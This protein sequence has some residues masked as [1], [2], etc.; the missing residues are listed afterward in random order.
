MRPRTPLL[1]AVTVAL[2]LLGAVAPAPA[3]PQPVPVC[4][5]CGVSFVE[6]AADHGVAVEVTNSTARVQYHENG[7]ATWTVTNTVNASAADR[8]RDE[9]RLLASIAGEAAR[10]GYGLPSLDD[11][12]VV[13]VQ[14]SAVEGDTVTLRFTHD[15]AADRHLGLLVVDALHTDGVRGGWIVN[16]DTFTVV[17]PPGSA[18]VNDPTS[19]VDAEHAPSV[20]G[21]SVTWTGSV[22]GR[23]DHTFYAD[24]YVVFGEDPV[25][26]QAF[27]AVALASAPLVV[28]NVVGFVLPPTLLFALGAGLYAWSGWRPGFDTQ[29]VAGLFVGA[30]TLALAHPLFGVAL[31]RS[32]ES[33]MLYGFGAGLLATGLAAREETAPLGSPAR[34]ALL[35]PV[36][37]YA[38]TAVL[39]FLPGATEYQTTVE[40]ATYALRESAL[41]L[42]FVALYWVGVSTAGVGRR[43]RLRRA[44]PLVTLYAL[45]LASRLRLTDSIFGLA[46]F[47]YVLLTVVGLLVATPLFA[48]GRAVGDGS[49]NGPGRE[50][51]GAAPADD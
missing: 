6:A 23:Y 30:G 28:D 40:V 41:V 16:A 26:G 51:S 37:A 22:D 47:V 38:L 49:D 45:A 29:P 42:P 18:V 25:P 9:P 8:F 34:R 13:T 32:L 36:A 19:A 14:S 4:G 21:R 44:L 48:L 27:G 20:D 39:T 24:V 7:S 15:G 17:G 3:S 46:L 12:T 10:S 11:G 50:S 31:G 33:S 5:A 35:A 43:R 1:V 2:L